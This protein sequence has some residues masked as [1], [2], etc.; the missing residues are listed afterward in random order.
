MKFSMD[1][2]FDV[3]ISKLPNLTYINLEYLKYNGLNSEWRVIM[4]H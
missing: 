2:N 4:E 3:E 1:T